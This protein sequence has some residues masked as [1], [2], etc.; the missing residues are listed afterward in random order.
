MREQFSDAH[1]I[2]SK[3]ICALRCFIYSEERVTKFWNT[4]TYYMMKINF[5]CCKLWYCSWNG[6]YS[7]EFHI[8]MI[9]WIPQSLKKYYI[10]NYSLKIVKTFNTHNTKLMGSRYIEYNEK[11]LKFFQFIRHKTL[12]G[13]ELLFRWKPSDEI[14]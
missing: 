14:L 1:W 8:W 9:P 13:R 12:E 10:I 5:L 4:C 6:A 7:W 11:S 3:I 2:Y